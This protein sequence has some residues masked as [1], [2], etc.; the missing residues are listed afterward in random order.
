VPR[1]AAPS[2][3]PPVA[4]EA[5]YGLNSVERALAAGRR[6]LRRIYLREGR[7]SE[8]LARIGQQAE[9]LGLTL[10]SGTPEELE[11]LCGSSAHQG[12]VLACSPL[13]LADEAAALALPVSARP[14]LVVLDQVEDP[15]NLGAVVRNAAAFGAAG[16]V[17]PRHHAAPLSPAAS[18]ASAGELETFPVFEATNLARFLDACKERGYWVAGT[19]VSGGDPLSGF[20]R[21]T[22]VVLVLGNEGR[23]L[24]PLVERHCDF[25]LTIPTREGTSLNVSA[26]SAIALYHLLGTGPSASAP[27]DAPEPP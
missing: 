16:L 9:A 5:L 26:A 21:D 13:P 11:A 24:R 1:R 3:L 20:R 12:A 17:I 8:R 4:G 14:V 7:P 19:V 2:R 22:P 23:G 6:T 25:R 15:Q 10:F 27:A 18:K